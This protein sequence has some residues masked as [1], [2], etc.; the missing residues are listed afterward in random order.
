V[1]VVSVINYKGGVGKTT[2]TANL[3]CELARR[4]RKVL[5]LDLDPQTSLTFSFISPEEWR[6]DFSAS[7]NVKAW[8]KKAF[9]S[10]PLALSDFIFE[11]KNAKT[12]LDGNG[13]LGLIASHLDLIGID[14]ELATLL[15]GKNLQQ[16]KWKFLKIHGQLDEALKHLPPGAF[17]IALIDCPPNFNIVTKSAIVASERLLIPTKPDYLS[18][19]GID[20]L[21][22]QIKNL[23]YD[24]NFCARI[25]GNA[26]RDEIHPRIL[27]V[28]FTM[29]QIQDGKPIGAQRP[30]ITQ[31]EQLDFPV[32]EAFIRANNTLYANAPQDGIPVILRSEH[33]SGPHLQIIEELRDFVTEFENR[34]DADN[35]ENR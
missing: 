27:G 20:Y 26:I 7:R 14:L 25:D 30:F 11:P 3:A 21:T 13:K 17:D 1:R 15:S 2:V 8:F 31:R 35:G 6:R 32:F 12:A 24:Y 4:G 18:T 29:I 33:S 9:G 19:A 10:S 16:A 5:L 23:V 34:L 28:V 22:R